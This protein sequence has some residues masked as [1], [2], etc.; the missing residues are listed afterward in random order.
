MDNVFIKFLNELLYYMLFASPF[1]IY[2]SSESKVNLS[3][4]D[5]SRQFFV[6]IFAVIYSIV[7]SVAGDSIDN[8]VIGFIQ[9]IPAYINSL[10]GYSWMPEFIGAILTQAGSIIETWLTQTL[11]LAFWVFFITNVLILFVYLILKDAVVGLIERFVKPD[12][13]LHRFCAGPFYY[14]FPERSNWVLKQIFGHARIF[15]AVFFYTANLISAGL[16]Y[17]CRDLY[18]EK[19]IEASFFPAVGVLVIGELYYYLN[20]YTKKEYIQNVLGEDDEAYR[21]VNYSL[22]RKFL[23]Q[24]FGDKLLSENTS[25]YNALDYE[26]TNDE[27][28]NNLEM[29]EDPKTV[30][31]GHF[32]K[33]LNDTG[34]SLDHNYINSSYDMLCGKSILFNN[35][36]YDDLIPYAFYP[37]NRVLLSHKK[38]LVVLGRHSVEDDIAKWLEKGIESVTNIPFMWNIGVLNAENAD[39]LDIGIVTRSGVYDINLHNENTE[40]LSQVGFCVIIEPSKLVSTAQTGLNMIARQC[41]ANNNEDIVY[42]MC[43]KNCDGLVDALSH[44]LM[45]NITEVSATGKHT[46]SSSYMCWETDEDYLHHRIVPNISRYLGLGTELSFAALKNQVSATRW[47]GGEAF[48][49]TDIKWIDKQYYYDLMKYAGLSASQDAMDSYFITSSNFWSAEKNKNNYITVEDESCNM[50][51]ILRDFSTRATEQGFI[52]VISQDY[53]LKDY[54][55]DN[56]SIFETDPKAIPYFSPDYAR[57]NRNVTLRLLLKMTAFPV[58]DEEIGKELSLLGIEI[59]NPLKQFWFEIYKCFVPVSDITSLSGNYAEDVETVSFLKITIDS[60]EYGISLIEPDEIFNLKLGR[61]NRI[62]MIRDKKFISKC[63]RDV[64]SASYITEDENGERKFLGAELYG[65]IYQR[66]LP[67]QFFT[68]D[69]KYYEMQYLTADDY[70]LVRRAADHITGRPSYRQIRDFTISGIRPSEIVGS[71]KTISG[72]KCVREFADFKVSTPGYYRMNRYSDFKTARQILFEGDKNRIPDRE[73]FNKEVLRI[74]FPNDDG[75]FTANIRYTLTVIFNEIFRTIFAE[76]QPFVCAVTDD[77]FLSDDSTVRPLTFSLKTDGCELSEN[78][79]YI[80]EDSLIDLGLLVSVERN[81]E[82]ILKIAEDYIQ[83]HFNALEASLNPPPD[84]HV[85]VVFGDDDGDGDDKGKKGFFKKLSEKIKR[86]FKGIGDKLKKLFKRKKKHK[87]EDDGEDGDNGGT[88][89][90]DTRDSDDGGTD[91]KGTG[92]GDNGGTDDNDTG[93]GNNSGDSDVPDNNDEEGGKT[94]E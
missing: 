19:T 18:A 30:C 60:E 15:L 89:D 61:I 80:L 69:G 63:I 62:Y 94:D 5:R 39:E 68:F 46:G 54:M 64:K 90:N 44:I 76:N 47:Y 9:N 75:K 86:F 48:P 1:I 51:E 73:Y 50:F 74:E 57:T 33:A 91:D 77:S 29:S 36:F 37:M 92:D 72:I 59:F 41:R 70:V 81:L 13:Q 55:A 53:I 24:L 32:I 56:A 8:A 28:I 93:N 67:G 66:F 7:I 23:R 34:F 78:C 82:R 49:V 40:F 79:I 2:C 42:C 6:P 84:P 21:I 26:I 22:L 52:N 20:G 3:K 11:N 65:H 35:P 88:D 25:V 71:E 10:A 14:F 4:A 12:G 31:F 45:T 38:V 85:P 87:P 58:D 16:I 43:D 27:I 83:W 17:I